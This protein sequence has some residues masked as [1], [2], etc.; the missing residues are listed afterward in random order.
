MTTVLEV[1]DDGSLIV[2]AGLLGGVAPRTRYVADAQDGRLVLRPAAA[3]Q[4]ETGET[5]L[6]SQTQ[7]LEE[8]RQAWDALAG[9]I[10]EAAGQGKS[11]TEV[12]SEM[13]R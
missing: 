9:R 7:T 4:A 2:P 1:S 5:T 8:W 12:L 10:A 11:A 13:R 3:N 6:P